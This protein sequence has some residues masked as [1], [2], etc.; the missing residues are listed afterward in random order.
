MF[1]RKR[2]GIRNFAV[3]AVILAV[4]ITILLFSGTLI[5]R[6][7]Q[8][9]LSAAT[10]TPTLTP[11]PTLAPSGSATIKSAP[12]PPPIPTPTPIDI[13]G[14][15]SGNGTVTQNIV[16]SVLA[17]QAVLNIAPGTTALTAASGPLQSLAVEEDCFS[18]PAAPA[19]AYIIGCAY[20]YQPNGATFNPA[21]T[22][23]L[24]YDPGLVPAGVDASK[25]V[26]A[27]YDA[28]TS[29]WI[30]TPSVVDTVNHAVTAQI[31][32]FS[33]FAIY[34]TTATPVTGI[35]REV[36]GSILPGVSITLDGM[37]SVVSDQNG[38]Y[39]IMST[40]T[41][42]HTLVAHK[43]EFRDRTQTINIAG[44]GSD[45]AVTYNFQSASG[46]IP[47][48]PDIWYALDCV[49]RWLYPPD[50]DTGLDIWTALDVINAWLYPVQ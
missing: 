23:T 43:D 5:G 50:P 17:G 44:L 9:N 3:V 29:R 48:A 13:S 46:L 30:V 1:M 14:S 22:L 31:G 37:G 24:K 32:H 6:D 16:Y 25:L 19:G 39:E 18:V 8:L 41:G 28:G 15:I 49:N 21:V 12:T 42:S 45:F 4:A 36:N 11:I 20:D 2:Y 33:L 7:A 34:S 38:Q 47:N 35:T 10:T 26:I 40:T 27:Y